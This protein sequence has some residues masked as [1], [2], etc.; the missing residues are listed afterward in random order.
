MKILLANPPWLR[1]GWHGVRAGSRWPHLERA[2][3]PYSP[4]PFLMGYAA[5]VLEQDGAEVVAIDACAERID[6]SEFLQR[7]AG[8]APDITVLEVSTPTIHEDLRTVTALRDELGFEGKVL[9]AGLHKPLYDSA[10][11]EQH[12]HIDGTLIGEYEYTLRDLVRE[13]G[14]LD[15][16]LPGLIWRAGD[17]IWT[18]ERKEST[19]QLDEMPWPARHLFPMDHYHDLPG[20]IPS[21]S[22][23]LWGSRGCSFTCNFCAW[24]QILYADNRYRVR[25]AD[26]IADEMQAMMAQGYES[27]YFD[28][29]TFN[30][31]RR[32]TA[33]IART[34]EA[35]GI[36]V[37]WAF[38]GRADTC[39]P[40]Q[41]ED[42]AR[43]GLAAVKFGVESADSG[44]LKEIGKNLQ[45][46]TVREAV[47]MVK[48]QGIK[49]HLT[50]MFGLQGETPD[51][52][53]R[54][55]D[56]AYELDPESAQFTV[57]VP[58]PGSRLHKELQEEGRL[59]GLEFED[60]DGYRTGVVSTDALGAQQIVGFVQAVHRRWDKRSRPTKVAPRI[61]IV[62]MGGRDLAVG[63]LARAGD[64]AWLEEVLARV[65]SETGD[66]PPEV[67]VVT[68]GADRSLGSL[69]EQRLPAA[70]I[71]EG[72]VSEAP[73]RMANRVVDATTSQH[74]LL[75]QAGVLP[76]HGC[77]SAVLQ[78][79]A[80]HPQAGAMALPLHRGNGAVDS[81]ALSLSR[82]GR[83][84]P[85]RHSSDVA[86][87]ISAVSSVAGAYRREML[88]DCGGFDPTL[89]GELSDADLGVRALLL[90]YRSLRVVG[91]GCDADED[92][93]LLTWQ[94]DDRTQDELKAW[95]RARVRMVLRTLPREALR[96]VSAQVIV[97][98][99]ADIYR[100]NRDQRHP[101]AVLRGFVEGLVDS[102]SAINER[103][104]ILGRRR[105][106][107]EFVRNAFRRAEADMDHCRWQRVLQSVS[108]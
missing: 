11:L 108:R 92:L 6:R 68:D 9:L 37:P 53:Q 57:A 70:K 2:E 3:S 65:A 58:F 52:M 25:S 49:V 27:I 71:I 1:P 89:V 47:S 91:P 12:S 87:P 23:Q 90:G 15:A 105:V 19:G 99:L 72:E 63:L 56:L 44:R 61:P 55:L 21:P 60:L 73:A 97:E 67:V 75:L 40:E 38:M 41:F 76:R 5:A 78:A 8:H 33:D 62:E 94:R 64:G 16:P 80:E 106:G 24:P 102:R 34:F 81:S 98:G 79:F 42:L 96:G 77:L 28:D 13:Q 7:C 88:E 100:A 95:A 35:R 36:D 17:E 104:K 50:F 29:D 43:S 107:E 59:D 14:S 30:L 31:G 32:R 66:V 85:H 51:S 26:A 83:V 46:Q 84:L 82:W 4:F 22:V 10:F 45:V 54:T 86:Q 74:I 69:T 48:S 101:Q 20:G 93:A 18:G 103:R 39:A